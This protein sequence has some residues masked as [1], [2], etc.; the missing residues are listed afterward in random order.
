MI[1]SNGLISLSQATMIAI[2]D[3]TGATNHGIGIVLGNEEQNGVRVVAVQPGQGAWATNAFQPGDVITK[4]GDLLCAGMSITSIEKLLR[5][6]YR[7]PASPPLCCV[8]T[9]DNLLG[10]GDP[11]EER[12][13]GSKRVRHSRIVSVSS[14]LPSSVD[15]PLKPRTSY[16]QGAQERDDL[17]NKLN[18]V[19]ADKE[20]EQSESHL[21][22]QKVKHEL[23]SMKLVK[24]KAEESLRSEVGAHNNTKKALDDARASLSKA[25]GTIKAQEA[26]IKSNAKMSS[27]HE[28]LKADLM[29]LREANDLLQQKLITQEKSRE[30]AETREKRAQDALLA[31]VEKIHPAKSLDK[32]R[33]ELE[34]DVVDLR[35]KFSA[36]GDLVKPE[37]DA[38]KAKL[39]GEFDHSSLYIR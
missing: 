15:H 6:F 11:H 30:Q 37:L 35:N 10:E 32:R 23:E 8:L 36:Q 12:W 25:E 33:Q 17:K 14:L 27:A 5:C 18:A 28:D 2:A 22:L 34:K 3:A 19:I 16:W 21:Q 38:L 29:K 24:D 4:I 39:Q 31:E 9:A 13:D 7:L 26:I 1:E 20:H